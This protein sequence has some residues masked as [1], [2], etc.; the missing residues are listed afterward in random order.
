MSTS[1]T[2]QEGQRIALPDYVEGHLLWEAFKNLTDSY[3]Q[4]TDACHRLHEGHGGPSA[5]PL[6]PSVGPRPAD[7]LQ[8]HSVNLEQFTGMAL[9]RVKEMTDALER[10]RLF[11]KGEVYDNLISPEILGPMNRGHTRTYEVDSGVGSGVPATFVHHIN[12]GL[13]VM[14]TMNAECVLPNGHAQPTVLISVDDL[15]SS[16]VG[17]DREVLVNVLLGDADL[18]DNEGAGDRVRRTEVYVVSPH[19]TDNG[20]WAFEREEDAD[21]MAATYGDEAHVERVTICD[22]EL[23][24]RMIAERVESTE[25]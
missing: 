9:A 12:S 5:L 20:A 19:D 2:T 4:L 1:I 24:K 18:Y 10:V 7:A 8:Q 21:A 11:A 17:E 15:K 6:L 25:D 23:A 13:R 22:A 3:T 14:L 16:Y